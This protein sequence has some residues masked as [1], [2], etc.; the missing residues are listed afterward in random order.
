VTHAP[1]AAARA[2]RQAE[3]EGTTF[4][5]GLA[6]DGPAVVLLHG[7]LLDMRQWDDLVPILARTYRVLRYDARG[8]GRT[9]LGATSYAHYR[10]LR[11]L[12]DHVGFDR[13]QVVSLSI[14]VSTAIEFALEYPARVL[15][16]AIGAAPLRGY[17][18]GPEFSSGMRGIY[19][20]ALAGD[21]TL[22]RSRVWEFAPMRVAAGLPHAR[23]RLDHM[24]VEDHQ[25]GYVRPDA[26][27][28]TVREPPAA[29]SLGEI[30]APTLVVVGEGEMPELAA[31]GEYVARAIP[32]ARHV[33]VPGAGHFVNMEQPDAYAQV[34]VSWLDEVSAGAAS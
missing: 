22:L 3:L 10:D 20:A 17:D 28:R 25:Y 15:S 7:G 31:K 23:A 13:V 18:I 1:S 29:E 32:G 6:G 2:P 5:F 34:I 11:A 12:L 27:P 26:P 21:K 24:I 19:D 30:C 4:Q 14:G 9:P 16:L 33:V 8:F